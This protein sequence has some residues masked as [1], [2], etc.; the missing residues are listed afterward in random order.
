MQVRHCEP[1]RCT[2]SSFVCAGSVH[3]QIQPTAIK[4]IWG[5]ILE[6]SKKQNMNFQRQLFI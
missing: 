6:S 3:L 4:I 1:I 5:K 2:V